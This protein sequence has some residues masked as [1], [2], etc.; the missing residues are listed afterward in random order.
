MPSG[1]AIVPIAEEHI[2][3]FRRCLD[4]VA[5][6]RKYLGMVEAPPAERVREFV[7]SV[8]QNG[9]VQLVAL[10]GGEVVGWCD[11]VARRAPGFEHCGELGMGVHPEHRGRGLGKRLAAEAIRRTWER[12]LEKV[13]LQVYASNEAARALYERLGFVVEGIRRKSRKID[14]RYDDLVQMALFREVEET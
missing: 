8:L 7:R 12:G 2:D 1:Y 5:R 6:E 11:I 3:G 13:E 4:V 10:H 9:D 14:G